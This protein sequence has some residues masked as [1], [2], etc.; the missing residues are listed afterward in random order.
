MP[1]VATADPGARKVVGSATPGAT[2]TDRF[3]GLYSGW[4]LVDYASVALAESA[5]LL[6]IPGRL[7]RTSRQWTLRLPARWPWRTDFTTV[8]DAIR[9]L[10]T[11]A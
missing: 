1:I 4:S 2:L 10:P 5:S 9:T 7:T 6:M 8:L 3:A 11:L